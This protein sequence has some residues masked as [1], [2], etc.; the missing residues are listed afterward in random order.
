VAVTADPAA[1][2]NQAK[3]KNYGISLGFPYFAA[4]LPPSFYQDWHYIVGAFHKASVGTEAMRCGAEDP[5]PRA[6]HVVATPRLT[7]WLN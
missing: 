4:R 3:K 7:D 1:M 6:A 5:R 2:G